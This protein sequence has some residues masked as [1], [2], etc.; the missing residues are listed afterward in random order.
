MEDLCKDKWEDVLN[1]ETL[2]DTQVTQ[3]K[4]N[5]NNANTEQCERLIGGCNEAHCLEKLYVFYSEEMKIWFDC[6]LD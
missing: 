6:M 3:D 2:D 4:K 5:M 1:A